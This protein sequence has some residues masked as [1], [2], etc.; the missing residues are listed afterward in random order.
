[1]SCEGV[2][3]RFHLRLTYSAIT[4]AV[5]ALI[6]KTGMHARAENSHWLHTLSVM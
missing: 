5:K 2:T 4:A 1:M 6:S 3:G